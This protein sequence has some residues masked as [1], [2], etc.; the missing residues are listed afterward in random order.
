VISPL[1]TVERRRGRRA[2]R[3]ALAA[4]AAAVVLAAGGV[5]AEREMSGGRQAAAPEAEE[6]QVDP[7]TVS[8]EARRVASEFWAKLPSGERAALTRELTQLEGRARLREP[9]DEELSRLKARYPG[10]FQPAEDLQAVRWITTSG[11]ST[12]AYVCTGLA[13]VGRNGRVRCIGALKRN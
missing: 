5:K 6:P 7:H 8:P 13:W 1:G 12:Q 2:A 10:L 9:I 3:H 4:V 11:G